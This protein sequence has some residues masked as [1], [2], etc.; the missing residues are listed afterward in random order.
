MKLIIEN[1]VVI[2]KFEGVGVGV[3]VPDDH[4]VQIGWVT[5]GDDFV[6]PPPKPL[7]DLKLVKNIEINAA[8]ALANTSTFVHGGKVFSCDQLSRSDIDGMNGYVAL[9]GALPPGFPG[10]W[11]AVD[12]TYLPLADV[13]AWKA[14]YTAMVATGAANFAH[15]Q[16]L[17]AQLAAATTPEAVAAIVW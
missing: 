8:R 14:F 1:G 15:A 12:N 5:S 13:E 3:E 4:P 11:K 7:N 2:G 6:P 9:Y 16:E 17:K 10:A